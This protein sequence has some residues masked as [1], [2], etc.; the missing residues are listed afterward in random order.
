MAK[1][2]KRASN[3]GLPIYDRSF[4]IAVARGYF[5]GEC[6]EAQVLENYNLSEKTLV[7]IGSTPPAK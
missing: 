2:R 5:F 7:D 1:Q 6:S 4:K 3:G